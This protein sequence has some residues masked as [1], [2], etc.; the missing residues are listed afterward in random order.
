MT[1]MKYRPDIDGLRAIAVLSVVLFHAE[2]PGFSGGFVGV[3][4]FFVISGYLITLLLCKD[5]EA[6]EFSL[7]RFYERRIRRIFPALMVMLG[8]CWIGAAVWFIPQDFTD[9][10]HSVW[11]AALSVS[12]FL[13]WQEAG[14]FEGPSHLKPLLHTWSLGVEE[15]FYL[16]FPL[17][18][19]AA[20]RWARRFLGPLVLL[21]AVASFAASVWAVKANPEAAFFLLPYRAWQLMA[22]SL[23]AVGLIPAVRN[24][25]IRNL[26]A[27]LGLA[28]VLA[29]IFVYSDETPFPGVAALAPTIGTALLIHSG[30]SM[31]N[32]ALQLKPLVFVGLISY[33]VYLWHWP[34][35]VFTRYYVP[36]DLSVNTYMAL[37]G[38]SLIAG[39]ASWR[40][41]EQPFRSMAFKRR[42][43]LLGGASAAAAFA[44]IGLVGVITQGLP[45]RWSPEAQRYASMVDKEMYFGI[46]DRGG[47]FLDYDQNF[48]QYDFE[49][50][51]LF[52]S[53]AAK[54]LVYGDSF[55]AHLYPGLAELAGERAEVRQYTATSC[56]P[57]SGG[58]WRCEHINKRFTS[59]VLKNSDADWVV[60]SGFW[61]P[62]YHRYGR[63]FLSEKLAE[64]IKVIQSAGKKVLLVG[65][66]PT[67]N[68]AV[69][70]ILATQ[71]SRNDRVSLPS[72]N[73]AYVNNA[74][75]S[76][77][78]AAGVPFFD[79]YEVA[80]RGRSC[81]AAADGE[82]YHWDTGHMTLAGSRFYGRFILDQILGVKQS[83]SAETP[84]P[85]PYRE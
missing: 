59:E 30:G 76:V 85:R 16:L 34:L 14:Y 10:S 58:D 79:P 48:K 43:V 51:G 40:W 18:L 37:V 63:E 23:L 45:Q 2:I 31:I 4:V 77:A 50:C 49:K 47:C 8:A 60:L 36:E 68:K 13:F 20:Y 38:A 55:A 52:R 73:N 39:W 1:T 9:F 75:R 54:V 81:L 21:I 71:H 84:Q 28:M 6:G 26:L 61:T 22:G 80:C 35:I 72:S 19:F 7:S 53:S 65:Q 64:S 12:N 57:V 78:A 29:P 42:P 24:E 3:D 17:V 70:F 11:A 67:Y 27:I 83:A 44:A 32:R 69:P 15:Q 62:Y 25:V 74:L 33:S 82:P 46:Y 56:R 41:V 66:S 5:L